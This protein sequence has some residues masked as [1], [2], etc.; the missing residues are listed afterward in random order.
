M[1]LGSFGENLYKLLIFKEKKNVRFPA[2]AVTEK[3][4]AR[5]KRRR[6]RKPLNINKLRSSLFYFG[7]SR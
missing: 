5:K 4:H 3:N 6:A 7:I 1:V 2:S